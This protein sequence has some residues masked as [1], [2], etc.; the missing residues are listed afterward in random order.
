MKIGMTYD[1]K[2][3]YV[4]KEG[5]P[6]DAD[7]EFDHP[8]TVQVIQESIEAM[9]HR[10][11]RIGGAEGVL[12][13]WDRLAE[14]DIVFNIAEGL[15][16]RN[17]EAQ[18]PILLEMRGVPYSGSDGLT[19]ALTLDKLM[20]KKV[21]VAEGI[22]TPRFF[23]IVRPD[24]PLPQDLTFPLIVKPRFEGS[25]KG[26]SES[27]RVETPE[28]LRAQARWVIETYRQ[29][30]LVEE[31]IRGNEFTVA[32]I[33]ND[34]P[35]AYPV[36]RIQID[37][38]NEL[39][40]LFYTFS[41]IAAGAKYVVPAG[42]DPW[43]E[44]RLQDLAVRTFRAV[45]CRDFGRVDFRVDAG[46]HPYVLEINPLPSLSTEDV[47]GILGQH[48]G[49]TYGQMIARIVNTAI[50]RHGLAAPTAAGARGRR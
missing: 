22:P 14:V 31:F 17:R 7:A 36:V 37:G 34:S 33:G 45:D 30:A 47:F 10:V 20:T 5:D 43:L 48:L 12:K 40:D 11:V 41:R 25:S 9:G 8:D 38:R 3:E 49:L 21:L 50:R 1:L 46:G 26:L 29:P 15:S 2:T 44:S 27:S 24:D 6:K 18:V 13:M 32:V 16:G 39:G 19:Q 35:E 42:I 28:A 4:F 23:E